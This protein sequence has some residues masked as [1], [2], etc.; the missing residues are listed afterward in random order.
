MVAVAAA[1]LGAIAAPSTALA[2]ELGVCTTHFGSSCETRDVQAK[3]NDVRLILYAPTVG[4][5]YYKVRDTNNWQ[6][7][8]SG[9]FWG[10]LS[11]T[12]GGLHSRYRAEL[13]SCPGFSEA[14]ISG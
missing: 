7:V 8:R 5:C 1:G 3:G 6:V 12:I 11:T 4:A 13:F 10:G 9:S 14:H 2:N